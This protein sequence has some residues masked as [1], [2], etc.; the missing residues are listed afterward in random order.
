[1]RI[2]GAAQAGFVE[3]VRGPSVQTLTRRVRGGKQAAKQILLERIPTPREKASSDEGDKTGSWA[4]HC[5]KAFFQRA[6]EHVNADVEEALNGV[7]VRSH[8]L[9]LPPIRL[10]TISLTADSTKP[11]AI[12]R[13]A[14]YRPGNSCPG[15][16]HGVVIHRSA[17]QLIFRLSPSHLMCIP[18][19]HACSNAVGLESADSLQIRYISAS[20]RRINQDTSLSVSLATIISA[21]LICISCSQP[22]SIVVGCCWARN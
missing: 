16:T 4:C 21:H 22:S 5:R 7:P 3:A 9:L 12:R 20:T 15:S 1:M 13:P 10:A 6:I 14:R 2:A 17:R 11:V 8:R 19:S 18:F